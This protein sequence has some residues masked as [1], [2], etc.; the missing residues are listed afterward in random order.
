[1]FSRF[2]DQ[3]FPVIK[4]PSEELSLV[5]FSVEFDSAIGTTIRNL[6]LTQTLTFSKSLKKQ[7][8]FEKNLENRRKRNFFEKVSV[9]VTYKFQIVVPISESNSTLKTTLESSSDGNLMTG[10]VWSG[11]LENTYYDNPTYLKH[12][13]NR[14]KKT[15][16]FQNISN[17][18]FIIQRFFFWT[19]FH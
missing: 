18:N 9:C 7:H 15:F 11:N 8:F 2:P 13:Q 1:M 14:W 4:F 6:F 17:M 10:K 19:F 3:T 16:F 5:V 12:G